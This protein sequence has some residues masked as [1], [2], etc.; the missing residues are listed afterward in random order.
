MKRFFKPLTLIAMVAV[1]GFSM[2][3]CG[4]DDPND[5]LITIIGELPG[6]RALVIVYNNPVGA[7]TMTSVNSAIAEGG[8]ASS[9]DFLSPFLLQ[10]EGGRTFRRSGRFMVA[11]GVGAEIWVISNVQFVRGAATIRADDLQ[12]FLDLP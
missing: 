11:L 7:L 12:R 9:S 6:P 4:N 5:G 1:F 8:L 2:T 10:T 3:A